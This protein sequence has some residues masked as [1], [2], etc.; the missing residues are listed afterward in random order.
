MTLNVNIQEALPQDDALITEHLYRLARELVPAEFI[1]SNYQEITLQFIAQVRQT[2]QFAAFVASMDGTGLGSVSCQLYEKPYPQIVRAQY[3]LWGYI[4][5]LYVEPDYRG[6]GI[7]KRLMSRAI[8]YLKSLGCSSAILHT[9][10]LG[11]PVYASLG[12]TTS[13]E[14]SLELP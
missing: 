3:R 9:S 13:N 6:Q 7:G 2:M 8:D 12:F 10:P 1:E 14:L 4:W 5:G 11:K